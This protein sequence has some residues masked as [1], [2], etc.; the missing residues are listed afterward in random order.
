MKAQ[1][2]KGARCVGRTEKRPEKE[3]SRQGES[4]VRERPRCMQGPDHPG[5]QGWVRSLD[6]ILRVPGSQRRVLSRWRGRG[7]F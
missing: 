2:K 4:E 7:S 6:F 5:H 3:K 1:R